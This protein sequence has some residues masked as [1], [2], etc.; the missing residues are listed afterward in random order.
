[1]DRDDALRRRGAAHQR[2]VRRHRLAGAA[3]LAAPAVVLVLALSAGSDESPAARTAQPTTSVRTLSIA[4][5]ILHAT[6][7][8]AMPGAH[9]APREAVPILMYH[10]V[11]NIKSGTPGKLL[12]VSPA[13]FKAQVRALKHAGYNAVTQRQVW[14]A[15]HHGGKLPRKPI[16]FSFDDGYRGQVTHALPI[17]RRAGWAGVLNLTLDNLRDIGGT[18]AVKR[19]IRAGWEVESHTLTHPD[20]TTLGADDLRRELAGSRARLRRLF[21]IPVSFFCYPGGKYDDAVIAALKDAGYKAATTV[22]AGWAQPDA[23]FTLSRV[24]VDGGMSGQ[25]LLQKIRRLRSGGV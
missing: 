18:R 14:K 8:A 23:S 12:R 25:G 1:M 21:K 7:I 24:R 11:G 10:V 3:T 16:V 6:P 19:M 5:P 17:L 9:L 15:W 4:K 13:D 20:L 22:Q 2:R